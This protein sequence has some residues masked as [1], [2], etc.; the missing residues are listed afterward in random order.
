MNAI[1]A[2][3]RR[4]TLLLW[5]LRIGTALGFAGQ[6]WQHLYW[7]APYGVLLWNPAVYEFLSSRG[8]DWDQYVGDGQSQGLVRQAVVAAGLAHAALAVVALTARRRSWVQLSGLAIGAIMLCLLACCRYVQALRVPA[9]WLEHGGQILMPVLLVLAL[10]L[11]VKSRTL[12]WTAVLA[13]IATF[14]GHGAYAAG[15]VPRPGH[16]QGMIVVILGVTPETAANILEIAGW[17]DFTVCGAIL[18]PTLRRPAALYAAV[19]GGLT[20]LA[21]PLAGMK[22]GLLWWGAD[23]FVHEAVV[24]AP[25]LVIPLFLF[26]LWRPRPIAAIEETAPPDETK[27]AES[28]VGAES[29]CSPDDSCHALSRTFPEVPMTIPRH[30]PSATAVS[31]RDAGGVSVA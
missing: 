5:L 24:R 31:A 6:A 29:S 27:R 26:L 16:F 19:W 4:E 12:Q 1:A 14:G 22:T 13:V 8:M 17:L 25:H 28:S 30:I 20:A 18:L 9:M 15:W 21:R 23:Q 2:T 7:D 3:D 10:R 11:G